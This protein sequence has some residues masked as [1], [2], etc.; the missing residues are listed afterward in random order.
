MGL[1]QDPQ[2]SGSTAAGDGGK[3]DCL[4]R[5]HPHSDQVQREGSGTSRGISLSTGMPWIYNIPK[6]VSA[7]TSTDNGL[8]RN[9]SSHCTNANETRALR[10]QNPRRNAF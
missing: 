5:R 3:N 7:E 9:H 4:H 8:P 6:E 1:Y 10:V 2:A